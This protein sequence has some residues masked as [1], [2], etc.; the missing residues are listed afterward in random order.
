MKHP[1]IN[2]VHFCESLVLG[3]MARVIENL[4][5]IQR[6]STI[7]PRIIS[8]TGNSEYLDYLSARGLSAAVFADVSSGLRNVSEGGPFAV[9]IHRSGEETP[10][11][12]SFVPVLRRQGAKVILDANVFGYADKG[13]VSGLTDLV[14]CNSLHTLWRHWCAMD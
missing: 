3:G 14:I 2:V 1:P 7:R 10:F 4:S 11:W 12:N 6:S 9:V 5:L 13:L 8:A